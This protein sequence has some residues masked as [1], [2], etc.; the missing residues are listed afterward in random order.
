MANIIKNSATKWNRKARLNVESMLHIGA[1]KSVIISHQPQYEL[2]TYSISFFAS[3]NSTLSIV[4]GAFVF[5]QADLPGLKLGET[6]LITITSSAILKNGIYISENDKIFNNQDDLEISGD[7]L[8]G[9]LAIFTKEISQQEIEYIHALGGVMPESSHSSCVGHWPFTQRYGKTAWDVVEQY[10]YAKPAP[11]NEWNESGGIAV[12]KLIGD[13]YIEMTLDELS[14]G[15]GF[16]ESFRFGLSED[17]TY[18]EMN[19]L[20]IAYFQYSDNP[21]FYNG[22]IFIAGVSSGGDK[23]KLERLGTTINL[24]VNDELKFTRVG[25]TTSDLFIKN[26]IY[27]GTKLVYPIY[28]N[29]NLIE[30]YTLNKVYN[31]NGRLRKDSTLKSN[32]ADLINYTDAE[33]GIPDPATNTAWL[34]FYKKTPIDWIGSVGEDGNIIEKEN[35]L[36]EHSKV[37]RFNG[38]ELVRQHSTANIVNP[39]DTGNATYIINFNSKLSDYLGRISSGVFLS[40]SDNSFNTNRTQIAVSPNS[41]EIFFYI[42]PNTFRLPGKY[43]YGIRQLAII[44]ENGKGTDS[45]RCKA[46]FFINGI[47]KGMHRE[48]LNMPFSQQTKI[49]IGDQTHISNSN[50]FSGEIASVLGTKYILSQK[51]LLDISNNTFFSNSLNSTDFNFIYHAAQLDTVNGLWKASIGADGVLDGF[52]PNELN[53]TDPEYIVKNINDLR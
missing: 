31:D 36:S 34:D 33:A 53:P 15:S 49:R 25:V 40:F 2:D 18:K 38:T 42:Q 51:Q 9:H 6:A 26:L 48:L 32:H 35:G 50:P 47:L 24:Y 27:S 14:S 45:G 3:V 19:S 37:I 39:F 20:F 29:G 43:L 4:K 1:G 30:E 11:K 8:I 12:P 41:L 7:L 22:G 13:G 44:V 28:L 16:T 21:T 5:T 23:V 17:N 52:T 46:S 10:N